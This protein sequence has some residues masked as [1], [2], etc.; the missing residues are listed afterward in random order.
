MTPDE[1]MPPKPYPPYEEELM[2]AAEPVVAYQRTDPAT[3]RTSCP[4]KQGYALEDVDE[5]EVEW[6]RPFTMEELNRWNEEAEEA[7]EADDLLSSEEVFVYMESKYPWL[8]K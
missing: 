8:C 3:Y 5:L 4:S 1:K 2:V 7:D 6:L